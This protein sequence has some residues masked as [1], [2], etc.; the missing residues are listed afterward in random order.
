MCAALASGKQLAVLCFAVYGTPQGVCSVMFLI[1]ARIEH[2][3][4]VRQALESCS[5]A[6]VL[7]MRRHFAM[8]SCSVAYVLCDAKAMFCQ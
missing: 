4:I 6:S 3:G 8:E 5:V 2:V 7:C 1:S